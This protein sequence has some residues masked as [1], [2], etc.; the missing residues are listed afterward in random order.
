MRVLVT[1]H[2]GYIG[3]VLTPML[4]DSG[5]EVVGMDTDL[6][7][8]GQF[9][10]Q[11]TPVHAIRRDIRDVD[12]DDV[13]GI[14]AVV[15]LAAISNDPV[16][17]LDPKVTYDVNHR[18]TMRLAQTAKRAGVSR[19]LFSSSCSLYGA[20]SDDSSLTEEAEFNPVTPYGHSKVLAETDLSALAS[21]YFSPVFLRN[22]TAY[23][24]SPRLRTDIVLNDLAAHA[25]LDRDVLIKS[26]GTPWR[27]L[28]HVEDIARAFVA[29]LDAPRE[30]IH[31]EPFNVGVTT[32]NYQIREL[33][34]MVSDAVSDSRVTYADGASPDKRSYRVDF[35]KISERVPKFRPEWTVPK[36]I[37]QLV[38]AY[39]HEPL[40]SEDFK[41]GRYTRIATI[42]R[43]RAEGSL[44][45]DLRPI[46]TEDGE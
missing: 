38:D 18:A 14:D 7:S 16:G 21:S 31:N 43:R 29:L 19:F 8:D 24:V 36:G 32:E 27:P 37:R 17:D 5:H 20:A 11:P 30:S 42:K 13:A 40:D 23:G 34:T 28:V 9:G 3:A 39:A 46:Q 2:D 33:A 15:H 12:A 1:G 26:D 25:L 10:T 22:A 44:G 4:V 6:Y 41:L 45:S 35:S